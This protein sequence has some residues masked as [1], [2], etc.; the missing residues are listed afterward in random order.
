MEVDLH[1]Y[2]RALVQLFPHDHPHSGAMW[3]LAIIRD[4]LSHELRR[5]AISRDSDDEL[6]WEHSYY[7]R[8][9]SVSVL[10]A[11]SLFQHEIPVVFKELLRAPGNK[12]WR[13]K[14]K[15]VTKRLDEL[16][17]TL[18]PF[19]DALGGHVRPNN[20]NQDKENVESYDVQG[21]RNLAS[22]T[23]DI[24]IDKKTGYGS[25]YRAFTKSS[26]LFMWPDAVSQEALGP[27]MLARYER[28]AGTGIRVL[29]AIDG[30]L[31]AFWVRIGALMPGT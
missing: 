30:L 21:L 18:E 23:A 10:E 7:I 12:P 14:I 3:R 6:G 8:R 17:K 25:T 1:R 2:K 11:R 16:A 29:A 4:D 27:K 5:C 28:V 13:A 31:Y 24:V 26:Y 22:W 15:E 20:A 9:L 19:R